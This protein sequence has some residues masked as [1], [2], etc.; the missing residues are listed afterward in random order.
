MVQ[1]ASAKKGSA[2]VLRGCKGHFQGAAG[3]SMW[4]HWNIFTRRRQ[5]A[6]LLSSRLR[7]VKMS[8][9]CRISRRSSI[10]TW[11]I[12]MHFLYDLDQSMDCLPKFKAVGGETS[13]SMSK[14]M[15]KHSTTSICISNHRE[16]SWIIIVYVKKKL[17]SRREIWAEWRKNYNVSVYH[18]C[19]LFCT[20]VEKRLNFLERARIIAHWINAK[21]FQAYGFTIQ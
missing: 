2:Q 12:H 13:K 20:S 14:N 9:Q 15:R 5:V 17:T 1:K 21:K 4:T 11:H 18:Y 8:C 10:V 16:V 6:R 3:I 19:S 7:H